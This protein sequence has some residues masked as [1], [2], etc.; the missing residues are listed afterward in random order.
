MPAHWIVQ[1]DVKDDDAERPVKG[2]LDIL[3]CPIRGNNNLIYDSLSH[4]DDLLFVDLVR[5]KDK[6]GGADVRSRRLETEEDE[7]GERVSGGR[8]L[9]DQNDD[10]IGAYSAS[11][12]QANAD[13][14][15]NGRNVV[16]SFSISWQSRQAGFGVNF[17]RKQPA[18]E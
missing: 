12:E 11:A 3:R 18:G 16:I 5:M 8:A 15:T 14:I 2:M 13:R 7:E 6:R 4:S 1:P 9:A 10:R 17:H